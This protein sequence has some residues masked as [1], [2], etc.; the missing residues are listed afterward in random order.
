M[1]D[2][3]KSEEMEAYLQ[4]MFD[5]LPNDSRQKCYFYLEQLLEFNYLKGKVYNL[6][7]LDKALMELK[8]DKY[9]MGDLNLDSST[10]G[11]YGLD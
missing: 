6:E 9:E 1:N 11:T 3:Q 8:K 10:C 2:E 7:T 4:N 5:E